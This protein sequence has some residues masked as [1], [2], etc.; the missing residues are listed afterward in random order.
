MDWSVR[1]F[2]DRDRGADLQRITDTHGPLKGDP[3]LIN[4]GASTGRRK[5]TNRGDDLIF[6]ARRIPCPP[7]LRSTGIGPQER[8][9]RAYSP[10]PQAGAK[11]LLEPQPSR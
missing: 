10:P 1:G 2:P 9:V 6:P 3:P 7:A 11:S 5:G 4:M 8:S